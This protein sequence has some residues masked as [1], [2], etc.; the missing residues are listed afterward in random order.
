MTESV[1]GRV[2]CVLKI[3]KDEEGK[4]QIE[5]SET[6]IDSKVLSTI[7]SEFRLDPLALLSVERLSHWIHTGVKVDEQNPKAEPTCKVDDL[8]ALGLHL[9]RVLFEN[10]K[11]RERFESLY[12]KFEAAHAANP[13]LRLRLE[14]EFGEGMEW[15]AAL[16]W[17]FLYVSLGKDLAEGVFLAGERTDLLLTRR[18]SLPPI[19]ERKLEKQLRILIATC[20]P[21]KLDTIDEKEINA[22]IAKIDG[23]RHPLRER[24]QIIQLHGANYSRLRDAIQG[25]IRNEDGTYKEIGPPHVVHFIGHGKEGKLAL[26]KYDQEDADYDP[27]EGGEQY[28]W[29]GANQI[30]GLF[31]ESQVRLVFLHACKGAAS[32]SIEVLRSVAREI[33]RERIPAVVAMQFNI[34]N[35]DAGVF[36][37]TFYEELGKGKDVDD[38]VKSGRIKLG[39]LFPP[40]EHPRFGTP[41]VYLQANDPMVGPEDPMTQDTSERTALRAD[42]VK[43]SPVAAP[44]APPAQRER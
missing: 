16:P 9:Y 4:E 8:R 39:S 19:T 17:E 12:Q 40:W 30:R 20:R 5:Y 42:V 35:S 21:G 6:G 33:L 28:R 38:A 43:G 2:N 23:L 13:T 22:V 41:V 31:K 3:S 37:Q 24:V 15:L 10:R 44:A 18:L 25:K 36:A 7:E 11:I 34:S 26:M 1:V 27:A 29:T 14:L 32:E